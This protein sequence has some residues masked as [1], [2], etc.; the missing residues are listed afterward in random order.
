MLV[1][2]LDENA[3][4]EEQIQRLLF[5][6][7][8]DEGHQADC[9]L[10]LGSQKAVQYRVPVAVEAYKDGRALK[11]LMSG[12]AAVPVPEAELMR[13]RALEMGVPD[14][15]ILM[16]TQSQ[17][18]VENMLYSLVELQRAFWLNRLSSILLVT[19]ACHMRRS[20]HLAR[21]L[22]P[23]HIQVHPCPALDTHTRPENW[24]LAEHGRQ[25]ATAEAQ[26][27]IRCVRNG[28]FPDFEI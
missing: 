7:L 12:G 22:F 27:V 3:L 13:Q 15:D 14:E 4:T 10:V 25:R 11:L 5:D 18:T 16:E 28:V 19:T 8:T 26:N 6:G 1:S 23:A 17:N 24:M 2:R 20:L 9:I 21:Y